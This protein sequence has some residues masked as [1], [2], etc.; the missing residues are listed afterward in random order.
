MQTRNSKNLAISLLWSGPYKCLYQFYSSERLDHCLDIDE[1]TS[2]SKFSDVT[3]PSAHFRGRSVFFRPA[4]SAFHI[5]I[6]CPTSVWSEA[7]EKSDY[8]MNFRHMFVYVVFR[9][10]RKHK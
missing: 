8:L 9:S 4:F 1:M 2:T 5:F 7:S 3:R 6:V 10:K